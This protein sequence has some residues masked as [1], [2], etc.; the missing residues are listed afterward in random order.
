MSVFTLT[1]LHGFLNS[2]RDLPNS[3]SIIL[4][5]CFPLP[6]PLPLSPISQELFFLSFLLHRPPPTLSLLPTG[7][8]DFSC[9][10]SS[11][12]RA[13]SRAVFLSLSLLC[14]SARVLAGRTQK[15][16]RPQGV[17]HGWLNATHLGTGPL[18]LA[19]RPGRWRSAGIKRDS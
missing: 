3:C 15:R 14:I 17:R 2:P 6:S 13:P 8:I 1:C 11:S 9:L 18:C 16:T 19:H 5:L 4:T 12:P 10:F 7:N